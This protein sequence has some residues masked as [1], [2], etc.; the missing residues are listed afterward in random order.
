MLMRELSSEVTQ[1]RWI[2]DFSDLERAYY[3]GTLV[4][5]PNDPAA[6]GFELR[7][8]GAS[9]IGELEDDPVRQSMLC[10]VSKPAAGLLYHFADRLRLVEGADYTPLVITSLVRPWEYQQRLAEVNPNADSTRDGVP[11]THV[12]GLA[13][14]IARSGMSSEREERIE[15]L[16][17]ELAR[18][19]ELAFYK[20]G[21]G[22]ETYHVIA[23]PSAGE[24][25]AG[26][27]QRG[28]GQGVQRHEAVVGRA[29]APDWPD[30]EQMKDELAADGA[31]ERHN[32][33][34]ISPCVRFGMGLEPYSAICSCEM[35]L[36]PQ[37]STAVAYGG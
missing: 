27:W 37:P 8:V 25:L 16:L 20:E 23:L 17:G 18:D 6:L 14:D 15:A 34:P 22:S 31:R 4:D 26:Y 5:V 28:G 10:R 35:P 19:G 13:F 7:L 11:P 2:E 24:Q 9:R 36:T 12:L 29:S 30:D 33:A 21:A 1:E 32:Y 3:E